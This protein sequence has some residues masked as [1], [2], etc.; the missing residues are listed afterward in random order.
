M[1]NTGSKTDGAKPGPKMKVVKVTMPDGSE[2]YSEDH[3]YEQAKA[4]ALRHLE[5]N[6]PK[7]ELVKIPKSDYQAIRA[8]NESEKFW[9]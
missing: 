5:K 2:F 6:P 1:E 8:T 3:N 7:I 4:R 9:K